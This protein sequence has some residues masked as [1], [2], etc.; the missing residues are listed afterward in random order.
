MSVTIAII[1]V[2]DSCISIQT[3]LLVRISSAKYSI[4]TAFIH[5]QVSRVDFSEPQGGKGA[6]DRKAANIKAHV[7]RYLNEGNDVQTAEDLYDAMTSSGGIKGVRVALEDA[8][9][10]TSIPTGKLEG[11]SSLNNFSYSTDGLTCW[12]SYAIGEGKTETWS[13]LQGNFKHTNWFFLLN[14]N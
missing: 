5:F 11:I 4:E 9:S 8:S 12:K 1:A 2:K 3:R 7:R 10:V 13:K 14:Y 6:C